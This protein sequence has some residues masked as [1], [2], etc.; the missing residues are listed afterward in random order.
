MGGKSCFHC[1]TGSVKNT[2]K[3]LQGLGDSSVGKVLAWQAEEPEYDPQ[4]PDYYF[5]FKIGPED[6][7]MGKGTCHQ[8]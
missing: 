5:L 1:S 3:T 6:E 2:K 8:T 4:N 7:S